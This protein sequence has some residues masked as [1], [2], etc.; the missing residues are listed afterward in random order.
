MLINRLPSVFFPIFLISA[1]AIGFF[2]RLLALGYLKAGRDL[3]CMES[4][5]RFPIFSGKLL[6]GIVMVRAFSA[7]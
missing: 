1:V 2:Y 5:S 3:C 7:F 4:N 6:E